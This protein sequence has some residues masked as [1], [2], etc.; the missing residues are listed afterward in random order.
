MRTSAVVSLGASAVLGLGALI[1]AR[2]WLPQP[3]HA[4]SAI[5]S[6]QPQNTRPVVVASGAIPYGAKLDASRLTVEQLPPQDVPQGAYSTTAQILSQPGGAPIAL[7]PISAREPLLPSDLSG[8]GARPTVAA[9]IDEG[10]RA[11][12]IGVSDV[13]GVGGHVLP[14]DR[15]DVVL[16]RTI[17]V[18]ARTGQPTCAD[19][20]FIR[21]DVVL[22]DVRVLGLDLNADPASTQAAVAHTATLEVTVQDAQKLAV[23]AQAGSLSLALRRTGSAELSPVRP[24]NVSDLQS[25]GPHAPGGL[26]DDDNR[27][28]AADRRRVAGLLSDR[29]MLIRTRSVVVVHGDA[30]TSVQVPAERYGA[31]A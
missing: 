17:P 27:L 7:T 14:G 20:K 28:T 1:V 11:Y 15:V 22:Q 2:I 5:G 13:S 8:G 26:L 21:A 16:T 30:A 23:A 19:C 9:A 12:T 29:R 10:M 31:G 6:A 25:V 3:G 24:I 4:P 18:I